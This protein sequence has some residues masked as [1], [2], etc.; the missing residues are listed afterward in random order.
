METLDYRY[1]IV[2][3]GLK[4]VFIDDWLDFQMIDGKVFFFFLIL[5][6][7]NFILHFYVLNSYFD[8]T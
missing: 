8:L 1:D 2:E 3:M 6:S 7:T 5:A 4:K